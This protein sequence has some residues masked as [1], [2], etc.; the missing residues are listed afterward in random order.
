MEIKVKAES[1]E[2]FG[3]DK[4]QNSHQQVERLSL[5]EEKQDFAKV[6]PGENKI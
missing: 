3:K 6:D 1:R 2:Y 5:S 4:K